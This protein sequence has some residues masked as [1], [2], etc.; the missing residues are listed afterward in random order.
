MALVKTQSNWNTDG[1]MGAILPTLYTFWYCSNI[2]YQKE[3]MQKL[4]D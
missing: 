1:G 3:D 4:W 2:S